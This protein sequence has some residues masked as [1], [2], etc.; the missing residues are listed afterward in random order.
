MENTRY[1]PLILVA[2]SGFLFWA[3]WPV[4]PLPFFLFIAIAPLLALEASITAE[5]YRRPGL[6]FFGYIY[7]TTFIWNITTTWWVYN[8]TVVGALFMLV[9]NAAL[10]TIP[11][12]LY[13][14]TKQAAGQ[15]WGLFGFVLYWMTFEYLH[16]NW[17]LSWP[18]LTFGN[19]FAMVPN[20][21]Q[22]YDVTGV[23]GGTLWILLANIGFYYG[24][25]KGETIFSRKVN[26]KPFFATLLLIL[27]PILISYII[28]YNYEEKGSPTEIVALQPNI[29]PYTEK[30]AGTENFIPFEEQVARFINL[31]EQ[32]L[33]DSTQFLLWPETAI[34]AAFEEKNIAQYP[35]IESIQNNFLPNYPTLSLLT[36]LTSYV[37]YEGTHTPTARYNENIGYY[38][39][40]NT[41]CFF[42]ETEELSFYHKSKLVPGVEIMPYPQVF[43][44]VSELLF[45]LGGTSGGY[46]R[47]KTPSVFANAEGTKVAPAICYESI[48]GE[49]M[50]RFVQRGAGLIFI[51]TNDAWWGNTPGH[52]Q[53]LHYARLRAVELRRSIARSANTGISA[54][55]NQKGE[56]LQ[57]TEY[58][59]QD[60]I[61][62]KL[63]VNDAM[64]FYA[65]YGDYLGRTAAWLSVFVFLSAMVKRRV[66]H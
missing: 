24:C 20:W 66:K 33:T 43:G 9:A 2:G 11:F 28:Y 47:Q 3:G 18:W 15:G 54:F 52:K 27:L 21:V 56:I 50:G 19:A 22:W 63:L 17:D 25:F 40:F 39:M 7:L 8:S 32:K 49:F 65:R 34:D 48:Y 31:S 36:G 1:Y 55:I 10:M 23:F 53:H 61:K 60:V 59:E 35:I 29:D 64:T 16:L 58:L 46:G 42:S 5:N 12:M 41:A 57:A 62:A 44:F 51:I 38:D 14:K 4:S 37:R 30:F 26:K 6:A 45:S 13:R